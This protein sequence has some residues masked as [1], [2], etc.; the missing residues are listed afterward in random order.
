MAAADDRTIGAAV[1]A[2]LLVASSASR[3][4]R[5]SDR[6]MRAQVRRELNAIRL[7]WERRL[8]HSVAV[9]STAAALLLVAYALRRHQAGLRRDAAGELE[10]DAGPGE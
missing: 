4:Q 10:R 6:A 3:L 2:G 8:S 5:S 9:V 1:A 7:Q